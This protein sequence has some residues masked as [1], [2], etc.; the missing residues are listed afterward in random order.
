MSDEDIYMQSNL[1]K[2]ESLPIYQSWNYPQLLAEDD[3]SEIK[4]FGQNNFK[5]LDLLGQGEFGQVFKFYD[6]KLQDYVAVK[7][8]QMDLKNNTQAYYMN[9]AIVLQK[10]YNSQPLFFPKYYDTFE[11]S[12][13]KSSSLMIAMEAGETSLADIMKYREKYSDPEIIYILKILINSLFWAKNKEY[14]MGT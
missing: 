1:R 11:D 5:I 3:L 13:K 9:E 8:L 2:D 4:K 6:N 10:L 14:P 7:I 12:S